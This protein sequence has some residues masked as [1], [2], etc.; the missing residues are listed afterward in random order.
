MPPTPLPPPDPRTINTSPA[1]TLSPTATETLSTRPAVEKPSCAFCAGNTS[2]DATA[3][4]LRDVTGCAMA[5]GNVAVGDAVGSVATTDCSCAQPPS[6]KS[7]TRAT[8]T[9]P[10]LRNMI[11][12][13]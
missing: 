5:A 8:G 2:P 3:L 1:A 12:S 6:N 11:H 9:I 4:P 10:R 7:R 13:F